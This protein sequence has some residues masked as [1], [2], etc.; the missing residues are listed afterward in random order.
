[1]YALPSPFPPRLK[2]LLPELKRRVNLLLNERFGIANFGNGYVAELRTTGFGG[3][4]M[5]INDAE[6]PVIM[7]Q[8][9]Y[10]YGSHTVVEWGERRDIF[11]ALRGLRRATVLNDLA[12][13]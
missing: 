3:I 12:E 5:S 10:G 11:N 7:I 1:M 4:E 2:K 6:G 8:Y 13:L 9:G